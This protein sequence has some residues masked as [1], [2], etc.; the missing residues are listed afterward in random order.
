MSQEWLIYVIIITFEKISQEPKQ[1]AIDCDK[2]KPRHEH[3]AEK[4][5][6]LAQEKKELLRDDGDED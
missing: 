2:I 3:M 5:H 6:G 4:S 1:P